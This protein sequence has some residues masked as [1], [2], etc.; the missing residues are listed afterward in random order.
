MKN[1]LEIVGG[2]IT[3]NLCLFL[4]LLPSVSS[5]AE[6]AALVPAEKG[7]LVVLPFLLKVGIIQSQKW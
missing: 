5:L 6:M 2:N 7:V 3:Q 1:T 4:P